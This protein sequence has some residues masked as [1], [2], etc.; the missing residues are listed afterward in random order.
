[1]STGMTDKASRRLRTLAKSARDAT[2]EA[3]AEPRARRAAAK[4]HAKAMA[5]VIVRREPIEGRLRAQVLASQRVRAGLA[6]QW[7]LTDSEPQVVLVEVDARTVATIEAPFAQ[8]QRAVLAATVPVIV[9]VTAS[10]HVPVGV[11]GVRR[12]LEGAT[13]AV[14]VAVDD[15][16]SVDEWA[17]G[18][19]CAVRHCGP[20]AD[21]AVHSPAMT[22]STLRRERVLA[23]VGDGDF[24]PE[25][26][27]PIQPERL[28]VLG[29]ED[30]A[31]ELPGDRPVLGH[32]R[33]AAF[34]ADRPL[35]PWHIV[36]AASAGTALL[37]TD[38]TVD[39]LPEPLAT[40]V[41]RVDGDAQLRQQAT[42]HLWQDELIERRALVA[43]RAVRD[44]HSFARRAVDLETI[45]G[46]PRDVRRGPAGPRG[47]SAVI[48]TNRVH[49]LDTVADNLARQSH[50]A[51][52][53]VQ[54]VLVL[55]GIDV[56]V[57]E[58]EAR[59]REKGIDQ[60]VVRHAD[61]SLTL[62]A[63]LNLG[64][65][66]SDGSHVAKIDDDNYYGR[67]YLGDLVDALDHSGAGIVG[68]WAHYMWLRSTGAV[69]LRFARSEHQFERLVQGGSILMHGDVARGL[70]FS[71]LPRAVDTDLLDRA[72]A[73]GVRTYSS[74]RFNYVSIRG[75][76]R[77]AHTWNL[78][79]AAFMNRSGRIVF[80][81]DPREH[82]DV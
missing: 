25:R 64:I 74:D 26:L 39:R 34:V 16:G 46:R 29:G 71:D 9:W 80:Y 77:H 48:S 45:V 75:A 22:G 59:F 24:D 30:A 38:A 70:R 37:A 53:D 78:E 1:M 15:E 23:L 47:V 50:L 72:R 40:Q 33:A 11:A 66:A 81:G 65:D 21:P 44:G 41:C 42:A 68:K 14:H 10:Q 3:T 5:P 73:A 56:P 8:Q 43:A 82:V 63:C 19:D 7:Q 54:V 27:A 4:R 69:I 62:G 28:D 12:L 61:S 49:E 20:A 55:H 2:L 35:T 79:D 31:T 60:L 36:E 52:G 17:L 13:A 76:D 67:H 6:A 58:V 18:L 32:Y 51:V 57:V